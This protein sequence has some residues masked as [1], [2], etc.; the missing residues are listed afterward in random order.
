VIWAQ[1][2]VWFGEKNIIGLLTEQILPFNT[3]IEE[4]K[5]E[6]ILT[7]SALPGAIRHHWAPI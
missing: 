7:W 1:N 2:Y 6:A 5:L 4:Q 3:L